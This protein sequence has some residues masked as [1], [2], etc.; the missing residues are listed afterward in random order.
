ML[1]AEPLP[2]FSIPHS[3]FTLAFSLVGDNRYAGS[4]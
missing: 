4:A 3:A 2:A 1:N